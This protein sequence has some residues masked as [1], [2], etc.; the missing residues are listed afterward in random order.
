VRIDKLGFWLRLGWFTPLLFFMPAT[1]PVVLIACDKFK[2]TLTA[3]EACAAVAAGVLELWPRAEC[4]LRPMADGGEGTSM[5]ICEALGGEWLSAEVSGPG[6]QKVLAGFAMLRA[7]GTAVIEMCEASGLKLVPPAQR[8]PWR[9][10]T[11]G[12]GQLMRK[13][14]EAGAQ[15]LVVAIGGSATNDGGSGMAWAL[16]YR[17]LDEAGEELVPCPANL[18]EIRRILPPLDWDLPM[19][20]AACD[21]TNP[22]LG[23]E[24]ATAVYGPQKGVTLERIPQYEA[25]L[26]H[27][28]DLVHRELGLDC[29]S[30]PGA[31]AAGGLG[32]GLMSFCGA[33]TRPGFD[34]VA[35]V[36][37]LAEAVR[38]AD[39]V[40]TGEGCLDAQTLH[41]KGPA[42]V[43]EMARR[44]GKPV[45]AV[46][47]MVEAAALEAL[48]TRFH[49]VLA[50]CT[51]ET[52]SFALAE[53][54][55]AV[56]AAISSNR[57]V[58]EGIMN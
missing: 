49:A 9:F 43:A 33:L 1:A 8:N 35:E 12:T 57:Q 44:M 27:F 47:G 6:G 14:M 42:G 20:T 19:V 46:G 24:G 48:R 38:R 15:R 18:L 30:N 56:A 39:L 3:A 13:A 25:G 2:G 4:V 16:G 34:L 29:R 53:P 11:A 36:T 10:N 40:I 55:K 32:F 26:T 51:P 58:L 52:L 28:A 45:A 5:V 21:V 7:Q 31:G 41:G 23:P 54:A 17:F 50:A 22:L 37:G